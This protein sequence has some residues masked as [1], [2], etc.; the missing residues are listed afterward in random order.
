MDHE[1]NSNTNP[2]SREG[3][4]PDARF[5]FVVSAAVTLLATLLGVFNVKDGNIAQAMSQEQSKAVDSW[6]YFQAKSTKQ[7]VGENTLQLMQ[8]EQS[9][10]GNTAAFNA[11]LEEKIAALQ[12]QIKVWNQEKE[13]IKK[14]AEE[15]EKNYESLNYRDDQFDMAEA[16]IDIAI[17]MLGVSSLTNRRWMAMLAGVFGGFGMLAGVAG[18]FEWEF[19]PQVIA[20]WLG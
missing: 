14:Q 2:D 15:H 4:N 9:R 11:A 10:A 7:H 17:A 8:I 16:S 12:A 6:A 3:D 5:N 13:Q 19:H 18:F 20:Q 1:Q